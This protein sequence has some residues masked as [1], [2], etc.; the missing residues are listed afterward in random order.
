[1]LTLAFVQSASPCV[2]Y[3][4][5]AIVKTTFMQPIESLCG[6]GFAN[7]VAINPLSKSLSSIMS[8]KRSV[9]D[10]H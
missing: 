10:H 1:M 2:K 4:D 8:P 7:S 3:V 6:G 5:C 9:Y